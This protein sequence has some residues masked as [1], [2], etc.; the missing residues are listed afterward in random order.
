MKTTAKLIEQY[1]ISFAEYWEL[2]GVDQKQKSEPLI[3]RIFQIL[4]AKL[5]IDRD[6]QITLRYSSAGHEYWH[7]HDPITGKA[8]TFNTE[9]DVRVWLEQRHNH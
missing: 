5:S 9:A 7:V 3:S 4:V 2:E 6:P 8:A 1:P